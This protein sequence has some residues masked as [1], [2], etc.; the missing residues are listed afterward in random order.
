MTN[1][2]K[3]TNYTAD[4][5]WKTI[6]EVGKLEDRDDVLRTWIS[7]SDITFK[8]EDGKEEDLSAFCGR[9]YM[10]NGRS[11]L[12]N[13]LLEL[14]LNSA[15]QK[16]SYKEHF[17]EKEKNRAS[18][19]GALYGFRGTPQEIKL[20]TALIRPNKHDKDLFMK[21]RQCGNSIVLVDSGDVLL[22]VED[23]KGHILLNGKD[24]L[25]GK[26]GRRV[27]DDF[28][29]KL[30]SYLKIMNDYVAELEN[31]DEDTCGMS[32]VEDL[33][34]SD[35]PSSM[36]KIFKL[37]EYSETKKEGIGKNAKEFTVSH[38]KW[39]LKTSIDNFDDVF[40]Y[41]L[42]NWRK[43]N[44]H[45]SGQEEFIAWSNDRTVTSASYWDLP[46]DLDKKC[47]DSWK[48]FLNEKMSPHM[49]SRLVCYLGMICS[50]E[51]RSQQ[52]LI[53]SGRGGEGKDFFERIIADTLPKNAVSDLDTSALANDDRFGLANREIWKSH[54]SIIH[55]LNNSKNLQ[56]EKAKQFFA[57]NKMGLEVKNAGVVNWN[58][59]NHKTI[60]NSNT[61]ISIKEY[62]NRRRCIPIVFE[63]RLQWTEE[64]EAQMRA[65][66]RDFLDFCYAF[67]KKC[68]LVN[69]GQYVVLS[70]EDE[71]DYLKG[72]VD[73]KDSDR[74][75]KRAFCEECLKD[76]YNTDEYS[77]SDEVYEIFEP[78][79]EKYFILSNN[80]DDYV[81][82]TEFRTQMQRVLYNEKQYRSYF[83]VRNA[84]AANSPE[85][86]ELNPYSKDGQFWKFKKYLENL[87]ITKSSL[88]DEN[89]KKIR[90]Y[91]G[92]SIKDTSDN[93]F[94]NALSDNNSN[95]RFLKSSDSENV[96]DIL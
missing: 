92:I 24:C 50:A 18:Y 4:K 36:A 66:C 16:E 70:E 14:L 59:I 32:P 8:Y 95:R 45:I 10:D 83:G 61:K 44:K 5:L 54:L 41:V 62:A 71:K 75:S 25:N 27:K 76:Y 53:I 65:D 48:K 39:E 72:N 56:S 17:K 28:E 38:L 77:D 55:E 96:D 12:K 79:L 22:C 80:Q 33:L 42:D 93:E 85:E 21:F 86:I 6:D 69:N 57:Q 40:Q 13:E 11:I 37:M 52:Y 20:N 84:F 49:T 68:P 2:I 63:N 46:T 47:P 1:R 31:A 51:N 34:S 3:T 89:G 74:A 19:G 67:Y 73:L 30:R 82:I 9:F 29:F 58:P 64:L 87:G 26:I 35:V 7:N 81:S 94:Y 23:G 43:F 78:I 15:T 91:R 90:V 88:R 60:V